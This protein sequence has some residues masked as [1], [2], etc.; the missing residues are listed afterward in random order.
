MAT[1]KREKYIYEIVGKKSKS[2]KVRVPYRNKFG[3][4]AEFRKNFRAYGYVKENDAL[5]AAI[6]WRDI[7][8]VEAHQNEIIVPDHKYTLDD[9]FEKTI[10]MMGNSF[11]TNR[12]WNLWYRKYITSKIP[13]NTP[14]INI[15]WELI[16][17]TLNSMA[18]TSSQD[19]I[20]RITT[21]CSK[22]CSYAVA[23]KITATDR[24]AMH[25]V[26]GNTKSKAVV[27]SRNNKLDLDV[28]KQLLDEFPYRKNSVEE[29]FLEM[30]ILIIMA[31][32]G[33]RPAEVF[34]LNKDNFDIENR[35]IHILMRLGS[36]TSEKNVQT[37]LGNKGYER[38]IPYPKQIDDLIDVLVKKYDGDKMFAINGK[39][40]NSNTLSA[41]INRI[42]NGEFRSYMLR[43]AFSNSLIL[44]SFEEEDE[45]R[46][47]IVFD[48]KA[49][50]LSSEKQQKATQ[51][52]MGH[53]L[54]DTTYG[55][56]TDLNKDQI[57]SMLDENEK[58]AFMAEVT[59]INVRAAQ[60]KPIEECV[61]KCVQ[62]AKDDFKL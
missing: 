24:M 16:C 41:D 10:E 61:Q 23:K 40:I 19:M 25:K 14:F 27:K 13:G 21:I 59:A 28:F 62:I 45:E 54:I 30:S 42:S 7:K 58:Q 20:N 44:S 4:R 56:V 46:R 26:V 49:S 33:L 47:E 60:L 9:V 52:L 51:R 35:T 50:I 57:Y 32:V 37:S 15:E 17:S 34:I 3:N 2:F 48:S 5:K 18:N 36:S 11:E 29:A 6:T 1:S 22:M 53:R 43:H 8:L 55:Y 39:Y 31:Y 38:I 12:K